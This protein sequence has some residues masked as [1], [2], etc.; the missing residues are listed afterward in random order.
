MSGMAVLALV[1]FALWL[2]LLYVSIVLDRRH[3]REYL[4]RRAAMQAALDQ[5]QVTVDEVSAHWD[6]IAETAK[7]AADAFAEFKDGAVLEMIDEM[8]EQ[9]K[10][11]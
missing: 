7:S 10:Q 2:A 5:I 8:I 9:E 6:R 3:R 11:R 1:L 4:E